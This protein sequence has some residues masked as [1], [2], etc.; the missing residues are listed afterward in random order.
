M[1]DN[2]S[3]CHSQTRIL[4]HQIIGSILVEQFQSISIPVSPIFPHGNLHTMLYIEEDFFKLVHALC[5]LVAVFCS[6]AGGFPSNLSQIAYN[7]W[8]INKLSYLRILLSILRKS[9]NSLKITRVT[10]ELKLPLDS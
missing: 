6:L 3:T 1:C 10:M 5:Q 8:I 4:N 9:M 2:D 7:L